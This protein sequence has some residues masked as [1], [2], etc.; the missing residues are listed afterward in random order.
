MRT[1]TETKD[2]ALALGKAQSQI[3]A[4]RMDSSNPYFS[5]KY[6][7][8]AA[9]V[10]VSRGPLTENGIVV[11][12]GPV[13]TET[14]WVLTTRL[15]HTSGQWYES[16][17]PLLVKEQTPQQMGS[18][19]TYAKRYCLC[20]MVGIVTQ[21]EDDDGEKA[22]QAHRDAKKQQK[23]VEN[24]PK[25][26][27]IKP[28]TKESLVTSTKVRNLSDADI[29]RLRVVREDLK[30]SQEEIVAY[31]QKNFQKKW[32]DLTQPEFED[33]MI[34]LESLLAFRSGDEWGSDMPE[35][36]S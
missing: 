32:I 24:K 2:I 27:A 29:E 30:M 11:I 33:L 14:G 5:S 36:L 20:A 15:E 1:S 25:Q 3:A 35:T 13:R 10:G 12:Q 7:N 21:D 9:V 8:L 16:D 28:V 18:A 17:F 4:A 6:A 34:R 23:Q 26:A 22:E 19:V 31:I